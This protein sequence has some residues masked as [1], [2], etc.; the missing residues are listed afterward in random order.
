MSKRSS[1]FAITHAQSEYTKDHVFFALETFAKSLVVAEEKHEDGASHL[2][3]YLQTNEKFDFEELKVLFA[4]NY[5]KFKDIQA[6]RST[7]TW[8]KYITK[9]DEEPVYMGIS[10]SMFH[11]AY[12]SR[13]WAKETKEFSYRDP[14]VLQHT[15]QYKLLEKLHREHWGT[16]IKRKFEPAVTYFND[17]TKQVADYWNLWANGKGAKGKRRCL[18]ISGESNV[19]KTYFVQK[20]LLQRSIDTYKP[21]AGKFFLDGYR[22][23][24]VILF[25]E[26]REEVFPMGIMLTLMA[27]EETVQ[28]IKFECAQTIQHKGPIIFITNNPIPQNEAFQNRCYEVSASQEVLPSQALRMEKKERSPSPE[29]LQLSSDDEIAAAEAIDW[30]QEMEDS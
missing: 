10:Y 16:K 5:L 27:G 12:R 3:V 7:K 9:E 24:A 18:F 20:Y 1:C 25:E 26:F 29:I 4:E 21:S 17:W 2:H 22:D 6:C 23:H 14:F 30:S 13:R 15:N 8:V 11:F 19:G 28:H